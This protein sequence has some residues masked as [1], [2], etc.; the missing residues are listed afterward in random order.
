[1]L[2]VFYIREFFRVNINL[3]WNF[4]KIGILGFGG[5]YATLS[6]IESIIIVKSK[7]NYSYTFQWYCWYVIIF[8]D[9]KNKLKYKIN[10]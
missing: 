10:R 1:M 6:L 2:T 7:S 8:V 5:D 4:L 9:N 3:F